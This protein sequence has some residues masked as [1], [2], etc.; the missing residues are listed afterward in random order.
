MDQ[1]Y[2]DNNATTPIDPE[3]A[4]AMMACYEQ[5]YANPASQHQLGRKARQVLEQARERSGLLL[6]GQMS[7]F[8]ADQVLLTSGGTEANN[9]ALR[10]LCGPPP[11]RII[12]SAIEHPSVLSPAEHLRRTGYDVVLCP[13]DHHGV[14]LLDRLETL[15]TEDTRLVSIMLANNETGVLQPVEQAAELCNRVGLPLHTDATQAVGKVPVDFRRLGVAALTCA[16]HKFHGPRGIGILLLRGGVKLD[17]LLL[18]GFQQAGLRPGTEDV[19]LAVGMRQAL[20]LCHARQSEITGHLASLRDALEEAVRAGWPD[21]LIG[22]E[23]APRLPQTS[24]AAFVGLDRQALQMALD[25]AGVACSTGSASASGS[26]ERSP[27]LVA[28]G[29]QGSQIDAALRLSLGRQ[30]TPAEVAEASY[31]IT[32]CCNNLRK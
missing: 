20:E 8:P 24:S 2:L 7:G 22:G 18:G 10:G 28:M 19:A 16:A 30:N 6:G 31:R 4:A 27:V 1:I 14:V 11:G 25:L 9:L 3:V 26:S 13:V 12:V 21:L 15:L 32:N 29:L 5:G 17:P 23:S